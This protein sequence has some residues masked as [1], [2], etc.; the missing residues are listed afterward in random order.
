MSDAALQ[1]FPATLEDAPTILRLIQSAFEEYRGKLDP[2]SGAHSEKL[3]TIQR[4]LTYEQG[5]LALSN[6]MPVGCLFFDV[7]SDELYLHRLAVLPE[8]RGCG[9][10][11]ALVS[12]VESQAQRLGKASVS[13]N[14]RVALP[15]NRSYYEGLGYQVTGFDFHTGYN[16][17]TFVNMVK[18]FD[19]PN[20]RNVQVVPYNPDWPAQF[21]AEAALLGRVFGTQLITIHHIGS[22]SVPGLPAK[23]IIDMMP[24]VKDIDRMYAFDP[25]M[26]ALG[27]EVLGEFGLKGRRYYRKGGHSQRSHH[28]H[29][30]EANHPEYERHLAFR[31]YL[32]AHP[33]EATS[34]GELKQHLASLHSENIYAYMDGKDAFI[35]EMEVRALDWWRRLH[36]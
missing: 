5:L 4:L 1:I 18:V 6:A 34:Y 25:T 12:E 23:P 19:Q 29:V 33:A 10:G 26:L 14:V 7:R 28:V 3:E 31:D 20:I 9:I 22:T 13:L 36:L 8:Y 27:Y 11:K 15:K 32:I 16:H 30:Y 24:V 21:E 35:K 17:F 2:P